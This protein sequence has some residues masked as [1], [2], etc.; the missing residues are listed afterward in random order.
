MDRSLRRLTAQQ[1]LSGNLTVLFKLT[2]YQP[3]LP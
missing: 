1:K 3:L 2:P